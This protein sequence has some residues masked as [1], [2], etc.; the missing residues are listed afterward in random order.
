MINIMD[1]LFLMTITWIFSAGAII[2]LSLALWH[3]HKQ[4]I[5][6]S[7][8]SSIESAKKKN[9]NIVRRAI[10]LARHILGHA[11]EESAEIIADTKQVRANL[12]AKYEAEFAGYFEELR[13]LGQ[14]T[15]TEN[16]LLL[17]QKA[18]ELFEKFDRHLS[19]FLVSTEQKSITAL[20]TEMQSVR[21]KL[22]EYKRQQLAL[23]DENIMAIIENTLGIVLNKK[24]EIS[25]QVDLV[26]EALERAKSEKFIP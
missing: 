5:G 9:A 26:C 3:E 19:S 16:E 22:D 23:I 17:K 20:E 8:Q 2:I 13:T 11:G 18:D 24:L 21:A 14:K 15:Q 25:D 4:L 12:D 6:L 7:S 10:R 1:P